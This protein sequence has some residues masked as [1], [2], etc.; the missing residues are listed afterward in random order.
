[1]LPTEDPGVPLE[2]RHGL[3]EITGTLR[4]GR[5]ESRSQLGLPPRTPPPR[6]PD[7]RRHLARNGV[8]GGVWAVDHILGCRAGSAPPCPAELAETSSTSKWKVRPPSN[9]LAWR[10]PVGSLYR[11]CLR[12]VPSD[13]RAPATPVRG[14][15]RASRAHSAAPNAVAHHDAIPSTRQEVLGSSGPGLEE[16]GPERVLVRRSPTVRSSS[17]RNTIRHPG[18]PNTDGHRRTRSREYSARGRRA[19]LES[20]RTAEVPVTESRYRPAL[21]HGHAQGRVS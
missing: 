2:G 15:L 3:G 14:P 1:M 13:P 8:W 5:A 9:V 6:P 16:S 20:P 17:A 12:A 4:S 18:T 11:L 19:G 7:R 10:V 21:V